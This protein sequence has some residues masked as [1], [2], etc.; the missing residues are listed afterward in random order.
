MV[1]DRK[2]VK[3]QLHKNE[4]EIVQRSGM[5]MAQRGRLRRVQPV[6]LQSLLKILITSHLIFAPQLVVERDRESDRDSR[7]MGPV[8]SIPINQNPTRM[9]Q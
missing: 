6:L 8:N 1:S 5:I 3:L 2:H 9:K 4:K 7:S